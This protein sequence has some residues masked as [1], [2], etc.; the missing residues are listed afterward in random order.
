[1]SASDGLPEMW[2]AHDWPERPL[3]Y[4]TWLCCCQGCGM[5]LAAQAERRPGMPIVIKSAMDRFVVPA[6]TVVLARWDGAFESL[7]QVPDD[8]IR[9]VFVGP[10]HDSRR[11]KRAVVCGPPPACAECAAEPSP[12]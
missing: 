8:W 7:L 5:A 10:G 6:A 12:A 1:M 2:V 9:E 11:V 4:G 3:E